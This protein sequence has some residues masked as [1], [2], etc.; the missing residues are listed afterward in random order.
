MDFTTSSAKNIYSDSSAHPV[1]EKWC[2]STLAPE[3]KDVADIGCGG[4][5]YSR[6]FSSLGANSVVGIDSS[7]QYIAEAGEASR[8]YGNVNYVVADATNT[9]LDNHSI[10]IAFERALIHHLSINQQ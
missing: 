5:I 8:G 10:D 3:G 7:P 9:G 6:A 1:W 2:V 4:G